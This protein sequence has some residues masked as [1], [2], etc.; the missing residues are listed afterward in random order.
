VKHRLVQA[1]QA[2]LHNYLSLYLKEHLAAPPVDLI[3]PILTRPVSIT[4]Q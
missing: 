3:A 2:I 4:E 1:A